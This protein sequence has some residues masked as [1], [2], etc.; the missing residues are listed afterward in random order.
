MGNVV[1]MDKFASERAM[2][3]VLAAR[4]ARDTLDTATQLAEAEAACRQFEREGDDRATGGLLEATA[5]AVDAYGSVDEHELALERATKTR[6]VLRERGVA[7]LAL[8]V[9]ERHARRSREVGGDADDVMRESMASYFSLLRG[10]GD[11]QQRDVEALSA[12]T[13][14][15][16]CAHRIGTNDA[17]HFASTAIARADRLLETVRT[18]DARAAARHE[19]WAG[20]YLSG[21]YESRVQ[22][23]THL[24]RYLEWTNTV[25]TPRNQTLRRF[26][27]AELTLCA[28]DWPVARERFRAALAATEA[29][30][31]RKH[32]A[33]RAILARRELA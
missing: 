32:R 4:H 28:G 26:A 20:L 23:A 5:L 21:S 11:L 19:L 29:V 3:H 30:L 2:K 16:S 6:E 13:T 31:P 18:Y 24:Q 15:L 12:L 25:P 22:A 14:V 27:A 10:P 7:P 9:A 17:L 1:R 33:A 8:R